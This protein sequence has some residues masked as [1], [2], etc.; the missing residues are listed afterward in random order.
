[1]APLASS[2]APAMPYKAVTDPGLGPAWREPHG[3]GK[4]ALSLGDIVARKQSTA[5][6]V[7]RLRKLWRAVTGVACGAQRSLRLI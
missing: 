4:G 1:M 7:M 5:I 6:S 3:L 2:T